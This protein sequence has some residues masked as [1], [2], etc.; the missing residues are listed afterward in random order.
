MFSCRLRYS[1]VRTR[2]RFQNA[3][4]SFFVCLCSFV[5]LRKSY[6]APVML[7]SL[8]SQPSTTNFLFFSLD[9]SSIYIYFRQMRVSCHWWSI[10]HP[11]R[12][13]PLYVVETALAMRGRGHRVKIVVL[14]TPFA[15]TC[16]KA[17]RFS[18]SGPKQN[19]LHV[20]SFSL[21]GGTNTNPPKVLRADRSITIWIDMSYHHHCM[22]SLVR[23]FSFTIRICKYGCD[24][25]S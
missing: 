22:K 12:W 14:R 5:F 3:N 2:K 11:D 23:L 15:N 20:A 8:K 10:Y 25:T 6:T 13:I 4:S 24:D 16:S 17:I 7:K 21:T 19:A 9:E 18:P 1:V